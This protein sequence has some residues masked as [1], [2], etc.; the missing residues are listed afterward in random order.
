MQALRSRHPTAVCSPAPWCIVS[1]VFPD[2]NFELGG[3]WR[4]RGTGVLMLVPG[5]VG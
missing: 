4:T 3:V 2:V 1:V 5:F